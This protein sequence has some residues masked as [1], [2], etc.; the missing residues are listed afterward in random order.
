MELVRPNAAKL[1]LETP[2][3]LWGFFVKQCRAYLHVVL[4]MSPIGE[5]FSSSDSYTLSPG[6]KALVGVCLYTQH[7]V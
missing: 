7:C 1:G 6:A 2:L 4:C 5:K 3:E